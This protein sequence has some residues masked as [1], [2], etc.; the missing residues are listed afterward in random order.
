LDIFDEGYLKPFIAGEGFYYG[1]DFRKAGAAC[2]PE[3][4]LP[5]DDDVIIGTRRLYYERLQQSV[6][7]YGIGQFI[8]GG[9][10]KS[11][12]R[13]IRIRSQGGKREDA[14]IGLYLGLVLHRVKILLMLRD[15]GT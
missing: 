10:G 9:I 14:D 7:P 13:L 15:E 5:R 12:A 3:S 11:L 1:W 8:Y 4:P 2:R 6:P